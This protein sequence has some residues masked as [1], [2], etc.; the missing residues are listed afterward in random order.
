MCRSLGGTKGAQLDQRIII[1]FC[2][3]GNENHQLRTGRFLH[4]RLVSAVKRVAFVSDRMSYIV[5]R[6]HCC[7]IIVLNLHAPSG[8]KS[9]D[10]KD[11]FYEE[12][13]HVFYHFLKC[14]M[15]IV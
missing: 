7:N 15:K 14:H 1:F 10:S 12:L 2:G 4:H 3:K 5:L 6:G 8:E 13:E 11:G 9:D